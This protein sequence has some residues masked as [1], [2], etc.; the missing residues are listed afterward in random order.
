[1][2][3]GGWA[4]AAPQQPSSAEELESAKEAVK[5]E[6]PCVWRK[7]LA[8]DAATIWDGPPIE[9]AAKTWQNDDNIR[10]LSQFLISRRVKAEDAD[11]AVKKFAESQP[12]DVRDQKLT[13]LFAAVLS[14]TNDDRKVV[15]EGIERF[16][17]R[18]LARGANIEK[19]GLA[20]PDQ[21]A[22][23]PTEP[24][25]GTEIDKVSPEQER[26]NWDVRVFLERQRNIPLACEIP[27]LM[28]ERAGEIARAIRAEMKS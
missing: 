23:L 26:Y 9:E 17:K 3:P 25:S 18:Q 21:G 6:W 4:P 8:L 2:C 14:R 10:K 15:L 19:Q 28:D 27:Q 12:A 7:T 24:V 5:T 20:L 16:H 13:E 22:A 1:M 11:A